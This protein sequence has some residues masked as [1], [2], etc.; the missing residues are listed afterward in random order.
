MTEQE[1]EDRVKCVIEVNVA[2][3]DNCRS[4]IITGQFEY[5]REKILHS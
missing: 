4:S 3:I 1:V 2:E 5:V